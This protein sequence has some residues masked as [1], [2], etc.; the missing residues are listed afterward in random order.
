MSVSTKGLTRSERIAFWTKQVEAYK[1]WSG[2]MTDFCKERNI[3]DSSLSMWNKKISQSDKLLAKRSSSFLPVVI[4]NSPTEEAM[5]R[6]HNQ[7]RAEYFLNKI[8]PKWL[9]EFVIN[10]S[11]CRL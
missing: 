7:R 10:L 1:N 3:A 5:T 2:S 11:G 8:D 9:A 4:K 6:N